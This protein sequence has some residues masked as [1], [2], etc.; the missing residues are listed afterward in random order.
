MVVTVN[1]RIDGRTKLARRAT[2]L[3]RA[4]AAELGGTP[5]DA[6]L[7]ATKRTAELL[8]IAEELRRR[9]IAGD[10]TVSTTDIVRTEGAARRALVDLGLP[11]TSGARPSESLDDYLDRAA[12]GDDDDADNEDARND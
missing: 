4:F 6:Q 12:M 1:R 3:E 9:W 8:A 2:R 10:G 5:T 11:A 7:A